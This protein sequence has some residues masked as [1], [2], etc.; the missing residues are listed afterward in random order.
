MISTAQ[1]LYTCFGLIIVYTRSMF[2]G[3]MVILIHACSPAQSCLKYSI[4][5]HEYENQFDFTRNFIS[6]PINRIYNIGQPELTDFTD[7]KQ[8]QFKK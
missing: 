7:D 6:I 5:M 2:L 4:N 3:G 1:N 8:C